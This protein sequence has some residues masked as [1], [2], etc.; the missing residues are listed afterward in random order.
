MEIE[1][2]K[3]EHENEVR[4]L[5]NSLGEKRDELDKMRIEKGKLLSRSEKLEAKVLH[6][7]NSSS[8]GGPSD[9]SKP[10]V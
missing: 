6:L 2:I 10:T 1:R 7:Q 5:E 8:A 9:S 4:E 3:T